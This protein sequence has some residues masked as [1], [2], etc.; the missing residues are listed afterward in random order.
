MTTHNAVRP[1]SDASVDQT[2]ATISRLETL[3]NA[4]ELLMPFVE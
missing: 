1:L 3:P 4:R 2:L